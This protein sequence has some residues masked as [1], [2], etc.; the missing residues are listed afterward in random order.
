MGQPGCLYERTPNVLTIQK[1]FAER[2]VRQAR[3]PDCRSCCTLI[4]RWVVSQFDY[5]RSRRE[6]FERKAAGVTRG[7][8]VT[9]VQRL[10]SDPFRVSN[11][12]GSCPFIGGFSTARVFARNISRQLLGA[13]FSFGAVPPSAVRTGELKIILV[14]HKAGVCARQPARKLYFRLFEPPHSN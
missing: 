12:V 9:R 7:G 1:F 5:G 4:L 11:I 14:A 6:A 8:G 13:R 3:P 2:L 10:L